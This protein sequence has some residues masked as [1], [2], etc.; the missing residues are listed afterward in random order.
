MNNSR[1]DLLLL[2]DTL[3]HSRCART[4]LSTV[5]CVFS[6]LTWGNTGTF[7]SLSISFPAV[8]SCSLFPVIIQAKTAETPSVISLY[9]FSHNVFAA[10]LLIMG[11]GGSFSPCCAND[12]DRGGGALEHCRGFGCSCSSYSAMQRVTPPPPPP[13]PPPPLPSQQTRLSSPL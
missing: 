13:P 4:H 9:G 12:D 3:S 6:D 1:D 8:L 11:L 10:S 5:F 2:L 7:C